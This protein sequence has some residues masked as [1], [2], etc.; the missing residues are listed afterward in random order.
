MDQTRLNE[1]RISCVITE[2]QHDFLSRLQYGMQRVIVN[3]LLNDF[4]KH[5][6]NDKDFYGKFISEA[7]N[8]T[9]E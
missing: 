7:I 5:C 4:M 8:E 9:M 2:E 1:P 3:K 6:A